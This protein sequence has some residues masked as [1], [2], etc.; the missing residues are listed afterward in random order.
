[1]KKSLLFLV[2][3]AIGIN[4]VYAQSQLENRELKTSH[5]VAA[6]LKQVNAA[7]MK[8]SINLVAAPQ[9][10]AVKVLKSVLQNGN[11]Y[12]IVQLADGSVKRRFVRDNVQLI[13]MPASPIR[14]LSEAEAEGLLLFESFEDCAAYEEDRSWVP[15]GWS[16]VSHVGRDHYSNVFGNGDETWYPE[17]QIEYSWGHASMPTDGEMMMLVTESLNIDFD[18]F[19][20]AYQPQDEWLMTKEI[21]IDKATYLYFDYAYS[22]FATFSVDPALTEDGSWGC[23]TTTP[24]AEILL[25]IS[26]DGG[27]SWSKKPLWSSIPKDRSFINAKNLFDYILPQWDLASIDLSP[28][29][30]KSIKIAFR[31]HCPNGAG[32]TQGIDNVIVGDYPPVASYRR[33]QGFFFGSWSEEFSYYE[34]LMFGP[35]YTKASW[36]NNS[37]YANTFEWIIPETANDAA[38]LSSETN[39]TDFYSFADHQTPTLVASN[40]TL[41]SEPYSWGLEFMNKETGEPAPKESTF[42]L[43]GGNM[44]LFYSALKATGKFGVSDIDPNLPCYAYSYTSGEPLF[45]PSASVRSIANYYEKPL[46]NYMLSEVRIPVLGLQVPADTELQLNIYK[47]DAHGNVGELI[48]NSTYYFPTAVSEEI[49]NLIFSEFNVADEET[50]LDIA[51]DYLDINEAILIELTGFEGEYIYDEEGKLLEY[52]DFMSFTAFGVLEDYVPSTAYFNFKNTSGYSWNSARYNLAMNAQMF[53]VLDVTY[54]FLYT[55]NSQYEADPLGDRHEF[56]ITDYYFLLKNEKGEYQWTIESE[57]PDWFSI[58]MMTEDT[59]TGNVIVP[60]TFKRLP[61]YVEGRAA[62]IVLATPGGAKLTLEVKQGNAS[63]SGVSQVN[64]SKVKA[65]VANNNIYVSYP[66]GTTSVAVYSANGRI[67]GQYRLN[68]SGAATIPAAH[69]TNGVY[70]LRFEGK[71][72]ET[73]KIIK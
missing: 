71:T 30:G 69:L 37:A 34:G 24:K 67:A 38:A 50:G 17:T 68:E 23:D 6:E 45:G 25:Y 31:F 57:I 7:D 36:I 66:E 2:S 20:F 54:P 16:E 56:E 35:A 40:A 65:Y 39:Y 21:T 5:P 28:Y 59:N 64:E 29:V 22:P 60:V 44:D 15:E 48:S 3:C 27:E 70:I 11:G 51:V 13:S 19:E 14:T 41:T 33:P 58:G 4:G 55:E 26:T 47:T 62:D 43:A 46:I 1:M 53:M 8:R 18:T 73:L 10:Q 9:P 61:G 32:G 72:T 42:F 52:N 63:W 49:Y 12:E